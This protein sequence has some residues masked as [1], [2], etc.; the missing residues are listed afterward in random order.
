MGYVEPD[1]VGGLRGIRANSVKA[2]R[3][4]EDRN[5]LPA[6]WCRTG[7]LGAKRASRLGAMGA[8]TGSTF[9]ELAPIPAEG[10]GASSLV[11]GAFSINSDTACSTAPSAT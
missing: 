7:S 11:R 8:R 4:N 9:D 10:P 6:L 1:V 2:A 3:L 5:I